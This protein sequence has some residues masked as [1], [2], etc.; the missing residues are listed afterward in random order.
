M[1]VQIQ[2]TAVVI[3]NEA[4]ERVLE[5]GAAGFEMIAPNAMSYADD[6]LSQ[7]SFMSPIDAEE[8][9]K[10]LE[11][12]GLDRD[13]ETPDFVIV[14][15]HDRSIEP[16]CDWLILFEF[17]NRLIATLRGSQSRTVIAPAEDSPFD[18]NSVRHYSDE[19]IAE[20]FE[21]VERKDGIDT[22][23]EKA[24]GKLV[25]HTRKTETPDE[26]FKRTFDVVWQLRREPG[27]GPQEGD[28]AQQV[29]AAINELQ[30]L[31]AKYPESANVALALGMAWFAVGKDE[32]AQR[33]LVRAVHLQPDNTILWKELGAVCLARNDIPVALD[34]ATKA[35]MVSPDD[36]E[37]LGN[38]AVVQLLSGAVAEAEV[39]IEHALSKDPEEEVNCN[40][41]KI[42][43]DVA[44]GKR[45]QPGSLFE[46]MRPAN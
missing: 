28:A 22:Y 9:A 14:Q 32:T 41:R 10:S 30:S 8:F 15:A 3:R 44:S 4:L 24:T 31:A 34:A 18:H 45:P 2:C 1:P 40:V 42:I 46:M 38:L 17:D 11:L 43:A 21:F 16:E 6:C 39:T 33:Q 37:L 35:V 12:H 27:M 26:I 7:A 23:R 20:L 19:E 5:D 29:H 13:G 36:V 25:Y